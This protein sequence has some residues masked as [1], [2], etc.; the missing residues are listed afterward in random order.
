MNA[1]YGTISA[2]ILGF[3][4][5]IGGDIGI[6]Y[7]ITHIVFINLGSV[8]TFDFA[9]YTSLKSSVENTSGWSN[10][11]FMFGLRPYICIGFNLYRESENLGK[12]KQ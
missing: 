9:S 2:S 12:P 4:F 10:N 7:D 1:P 3:N 11:Y 6:K 8:L 5:G